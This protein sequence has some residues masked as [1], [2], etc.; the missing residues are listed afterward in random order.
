VNQLYLAEQKQ[1]QRNIFDF[2]EETTLYIGKQG[3][4]KCSDTL[5]V[6]FFRCLASFRHNKTTVVLPL[7]KCSQCGCYIL[8][9]KPYEKNQHIFRN[10]K[11]IKLKTG[12][13]IIAPISVGKSCGSPKVVT[14][15]IPSSVQQAAFCPFQGGRF[16]GK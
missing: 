1:L 9:S 8:G 14:Q 3:L 16:S 15:P 7:L 6:N 10:Y 11:L 13:E 12:R 5:P 2:S 4:H